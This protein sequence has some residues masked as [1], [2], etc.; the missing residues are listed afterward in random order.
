[1]P[2]N[3][4]WELDPHTK[5]KHEILENYLKA[6][7][8]ILS[9]WN[10]QIIYLDGFAGP[11][12]YKNGE[13]GSP[14]I[15]LRTLDEH[16]LKPQKRCKN[17]FVFVEKD[18]KRAQILKAV[19]KDKYPKLPRNCTYEIIGEEFAP[20]LESVLDNIESQGAKLAPTFA[21]IDPFGFS[22]LPMELIGRMMLYD[23]CEVLITFMSGFV[24]RFNDELREDVLDE[25]F[26][27]PKW[28]EGREIKNPDERRKFWI[29]TY[30]KQLIDMGN[31]KFTLSFEMIGKHNQTVYNLVYGTK[32]WR[33]IEVMKEAMYK[34]DRRGTYTFSDVT[35]VNQSFLIDY[36]DDTHWASSAANMVYDEFRGQSKSVDEIHQFVV[37]NTPYVFRRSLI[38]KPL[39]QMTPPKIIK[40]V[41]RKKIYSYPEGCIITFKD[42]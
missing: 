19:L 3:T 32:H 22:G 1:M 27:A 16:I 36:S 35:D 39:E 5:A 14:I 33:G 30:V 21:F 42:D 11:G 12:I 40:V 23:K 8:P 13:E 17:F 6:W 41:G 10:K 28:R 15:A 20:T 26:G 37:L 25:L 31:A 34:V 38:L 2:N 4:I 29:D 9:K 24:N 18:Q 7:F